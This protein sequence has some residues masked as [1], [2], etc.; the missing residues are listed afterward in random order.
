[1][2]VIISII[3]F[4]GFIAVVGILAE[5]IF[6]EAKKSGNEIQNELDSIKDKI[7][8]RIV[9]EKDTFLILDYSF[10]KSNYTLSNGTEVS[11][12]LIEKLKIVK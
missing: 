1:M 5:K 10:L 6:D 4:F 7:G 9:L 11:F 3:L 8:K 2:K 12:E